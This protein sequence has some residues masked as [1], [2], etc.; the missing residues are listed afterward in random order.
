MPLSL[1]DWAG[2]VYWK[3]AHNAVTSGQGCRLLPAWLHRAADTAGVLVLP[4]PEAGAAPTG[5]AA[6]ALP[7]CLEPSTWLVSFLVVCVLANALLLLLGT[8]AWRQ[9]TGRQQHE[10]RWS[11]GVP[12]DGH[13]S[14]GKAG[15]P[16]GLQPGCGSSKGCSGD[17]AAH[18]DAV[19]TAAAA[20]VVGGTGGMGRC[21]T[22][23]A[24][25]DCGQADGLESGAADG[26]SRG[27]SAASNVMA[28]AQAAGDV[29]DLPA[30]ASRDGATAP[31]G[32][33]LLVGGIC[34]ALPPRPSAVDAAG[35]GADVAVGQQ[36]SAWAGD[37][38]GRSGGVAAGSA[39]VAAV[40]AAGGAEQA[41]PDV[42]TEP[43]TVAVKV[44]GHVPCGG[45]VGA[46]W[47]VVGAC[48]VQGTV[49]PV[50]WLCSM[51]AGAG[52]GAHRRRRCYK[53][54]GTGGWLFCSLGPCVQQLGS[55]TPGHDSLLSLLAKVPLGRALRLKHQQHLWCPAHV[56]R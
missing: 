49:A 2:W 18:Q 11:S 28:A 44:G 30:E 53:G 51:I 9:P 56:N 6:A 35:C 40:V 43:F 42:D 36:R 10:R 39:D 27:G 22:E 37:A 23:G 32:I 24:L 41:V 1:L 33:H 29:V 46:R 12:A 47:H 13:A 8:W 55:C 31:Q 15:Q 16:S 25:S 4:P 17:E 20:G 52:G 26:S 14:E 7:A 38:A 50:A 3:A 19:G 34:V 54:L 5:P 45:R 48:V 21:S